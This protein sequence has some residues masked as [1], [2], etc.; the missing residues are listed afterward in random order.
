MA[1]QEMCVLVLI[2]EAANVARDSD[3]EA[4]QDS[5]DELWSARDNEMTNKK[6][7]ESTGRF[8]L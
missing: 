5:K 6:S 1:F 8:W 3:V 4:I 2:E 7:Y